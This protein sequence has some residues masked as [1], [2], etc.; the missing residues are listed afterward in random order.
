MKRAEAFGLAALERSSQK[1]AIP[2]SIVPCVD[3]PVDGASSIQLPVA[4]RNL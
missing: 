3:Q 2:N 1:N 4:E